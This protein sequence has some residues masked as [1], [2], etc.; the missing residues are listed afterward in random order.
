MRELL[1]VYKKNN[2]YYFTKQSEPRV[3]LKKKSVQYINIRRPEMTDKEKLIR[4]LIAKISVIAP[5]DINGAFPPITTARFG[6][7]NY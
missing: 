4:S 5:E 2:T 7:Q 6:I 3:Y 1:P